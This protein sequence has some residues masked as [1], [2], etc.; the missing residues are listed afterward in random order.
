MCYLT[1]AEELFKFSTAPI[2]K[3]IARYTL[4]RAFYTGHSIPLTDKLPVFMK[5][6]RKGYLKYIGIKS[7]LVFWLK[8][9]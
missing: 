9:S 3:R 1:V 6:T 7:I 4:E 5:A 2:I 8:G